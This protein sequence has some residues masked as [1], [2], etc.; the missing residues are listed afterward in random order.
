MGNQLKAP[1]E[2]ARDFQCEHSTKSVED[3]LSEHLHGGYIWITP[4]VFMVA[5]GVQWDGEREEIVH[6]GSE[7][8]AWFIELA[9]CNDGSNFIAEFMRVAPHPQPW[10]LWCRRGE[11]RVRA[12]RWNKLMK[13]VGGQ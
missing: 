12:F 11:M 1:W 9:A 2:L 8:N 4:A 3:V 5:C 13:K 6:D 7:H 10:V